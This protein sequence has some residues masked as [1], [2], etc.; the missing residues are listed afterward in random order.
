MSYYLLPKNHNL[1]YKSLECVEDK[2]IEPV[3]SFSLASYLYEIKRKISEK[4]IEWDMIKKYTNPYEYIHSIIPGKKKSVSKYKP[5]SRSYFKMLEILKTFEFNFEKNINTFHLAEGPGGFI[6]AMV[7]YRKCLKDNY[8][9]ITLLDDQEDPTI[10]SWKKSESF[11]KSNPNVFIEKGR[12]KTGD[13]LSLNNFLYCKE[14]YGS[15]MDF[16]TG[17]G[18]F[19]FSV[20]FNK[21]EIS[22]SKLL[23]AQVVYAIILQ[24]KKR[25]FC[26][27]DF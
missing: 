14:K 7:T 16:I 11:L 15:S 27:K 25:F 4:G 10:P 1:I 21:Q 19:D 17:D 18:G 24:K 5:L 3:I 2:T 12:D 23:F 13:I 20:D 6:E 8:I 9:G 26:I 22:I